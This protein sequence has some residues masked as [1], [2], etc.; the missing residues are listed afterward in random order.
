[1]KRFGEFKLQKNCD[2]SYSSESLFGPVKITLEVVHTSYGL[3]KWQAVKLTFFAPWTCNVLPFIHFQIFFFM[4][5]LCRLLRTVS[6][7]QNWLARLWKDQSF[8]QINRLFPWVLLNKTT[9][10]CILLILGFDWSGW[11]VLIKSEILIATGMVWPVSSDKQKVPLVYKKITV[12][13]CLFN[14]VQYLH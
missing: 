11:I 3:P 10:S 2:Q 6:K 1:M 12:I 4:T 14:F 5:Y 8:W 9:L 13:I 7:S